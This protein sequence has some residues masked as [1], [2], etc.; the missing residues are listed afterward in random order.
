MERKEDREPGTVVEEVVVVGMDEEEGDD[1][2]VEEEE[3]EEEGREKFVLCLEGGGAGVERAVS[4]KE[5][6]IWLYGRGCDW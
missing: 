4:V 3:E 1:D 6:G 2:E 5:G